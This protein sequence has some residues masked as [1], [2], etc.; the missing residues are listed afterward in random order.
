MWPWGHLAV[1]YLA[2]VASRRPL[3]D[4]AAL[5][6]AFG[7]QFPDLVDKP[8]AW[9]LGVIPNGRSLAHSAIVA[10][11]LLI[12]LW[13]IVDNRELV[14]AFGLGYASHL[15]ADGLYPLLE[16]RFAELAY[17]GWPLLAPVEYTGST[18]IVARFAELSAQLAA[19]EIPPTVV[20][21]LTLAVVAAIIWVR[22]GAPGLTVPRR[23]RR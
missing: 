13:R 10:T 3:D 2:A 19:G 9:Y 23:W 15:A 4:R 22:R 21:E 17:L 18:S 20:F 1:G 12:V 11:L 14:L 6:L 5:L 16:G 7:T 8:L